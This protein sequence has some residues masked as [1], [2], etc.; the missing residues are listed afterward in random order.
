MQISR[1][2]LGVF[3]TYKGL[4]FG[5]LRIKVQGEHVNLYSKVG[6][7]SG[8][9]ICFDEFDVSICEVEFVL[10]VEKETVFFNLLVQ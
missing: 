7:T 8:H 5:N 10:V 4:V 3:P 1:K 9:Q 6:E 2:Q